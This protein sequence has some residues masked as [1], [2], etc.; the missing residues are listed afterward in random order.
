[1]QFI[2]TILLSVI[3]LTLLFGGSVA[4]KPPMQPPYA[5]LSMANSVAV[6]IFLKDL[7]NY[8]NKDPNN[9]LTYTIITNQAD[10]VATYSTGTMTI[11]KQGKLLGVAPLLFSN[12]VWNCPP[13]DP[14]SIEQYMN[15]FSP[16]NVNLLSLSLDP[17]SGQ[18]DLMLIP[19]PA[20]VPVFYKIIDLQKG[21]DVL[22]GFY[23]APKMMVVT[24]IQKNKHPAGPK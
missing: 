7:V 22:Y 16:K 9:Y 23:D 5:N 12:R 3:V 6:Q 19:N 1:M 13:C 2:K 15:P 14:D 10:G 4:Q 24:S 11:D 21:N 18:G 17:K 8:V 20:A